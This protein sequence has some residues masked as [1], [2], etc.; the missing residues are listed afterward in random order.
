VEKPDLAT[1][2]AYLATGRYSWNSGMFLFRA[3]R[4]LAEMEAH[5]PDILAS[6]ADAVGGEAGAKVVFLAEEAF[7]SCRA[8]SIDYAV[9]EHTDRAAV[10]PF[11]AGWHDVG[12]WAALW[13]LEEHD[14]AGNAV[15]GAAYLEEVSRSLVLAGDRPVAVIGLD[16]VVV[17]DT[18]DAVLVCAREQAQAVKEIV[19]RLEADGRPEAVRPPPG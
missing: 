2:E 10:V 15:S 4:Y 9:M 3:D 17:V 7:A 13:E 12:S 16:D 19:S 1:A 6:V 8:D 14:T 5:A 11:A 18:G